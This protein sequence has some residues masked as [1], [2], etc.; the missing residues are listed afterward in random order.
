[1]NLRHGLCAFVQ[2]AI[3]ST[4][5]FAQSDSLA[6]PASNYETTRALPPAPIGEVAQPL[7]VLKVL[8]LQIDST[9]NDSVKDE[10]RKSI[11]AMD[12]AHTNNGRLVEQLKSNSAVTVLSRPQVSLLDGTPG[13]VSI[14]EERVL[15]YMV[16]DQK[17][18]FRLTNTKPMRLGMDFCVTAHA[19]RSRNRFTID[20]V[21]LT[22]YAIEGREQVEGT[23]LPVGKPR[24]AKR[25]VTTSLELAAGKTG[26]VELQ[27]S[28]SKQVWVALSASFMQEEQDVKQPTVL[29][30]PRP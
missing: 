3:L 18:L 22:L 10:L 27:L 28:E 8:I 7:I 15:Q 29:P 23:E 26:L 13:Q 2:L 14:G 1:M 24:I 20:P 30:H 19:K 17:G 12:D 16:P 5:T 6:S 4:A 21:E 25:S 9:D 11:H